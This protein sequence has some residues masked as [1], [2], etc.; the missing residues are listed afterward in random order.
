MFPTRIQLTLLPRPPHR[1]PSSY[2]PQAA[3][4]PP[5]VRGPPFGPNSHDAGDPHAAFGVILRDLAAAS[6]GTP[7]DRMLVS[8][9]ASPAEL[10]DVAAVETGPRG[11]AHHSQS[12]LPRRV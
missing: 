12:L 7:E 5:I 3:A 4:A 6:R 1:R 2:L 8:S 10:S 9:G 11:S